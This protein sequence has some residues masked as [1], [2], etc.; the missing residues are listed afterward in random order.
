MKKNLFV[1]VLCFVSLYHFSQNVGIGNNS[2]Q[3]KLHVSGAIRSDTLI[4][5]G[6]PVRHLFSAPNGR[7]YDSLVLPSP[8]D[9]LI[10]G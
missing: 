2:P 5:T 7:I 8:A 10:N 4:Y 6:S 3:S 9:W 1:L